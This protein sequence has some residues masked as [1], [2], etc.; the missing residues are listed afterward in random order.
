MQIS[1]DACA[2]L[3]LVGAGYAIW[4]AHFRQPFVG[5][6]Q[7]ADVCHVCKRLV[8]RYHTPDGVRKCANCDPEGFI[9]SIS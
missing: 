3:A 5:Q 2:V 7:P 4:H 9:K 8:A 6:P 1:F